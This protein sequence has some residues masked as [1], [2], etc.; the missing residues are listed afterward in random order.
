M[1]GPSSA[2]VYRLVCFFKS[3]PW[4]PPFKAIGGIGGVADFM[5]QERIQQELESRMTQMQEGEDD[6]DIPEI[7]TT[8]PVG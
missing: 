4:P 1:I 7:D 2:Q 3:P 6:V 5:P 8:T